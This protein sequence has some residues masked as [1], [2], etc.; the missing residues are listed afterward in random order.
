MW[1][2]SRV[3]RFPRSVHASVLG[4]PGVIRVTLTSVCG[5]GLRLGEQAQEELQLKKLLCRFVKNGFMLALDGIDPKTGPTKA[6]LIQ[7]AFSKA[8][9][10]LYPEIP[11]GKPGEGG[12][13]W[14]AGYNADPPT[15]T[16]E[17]ELTA[18]IDELNK[19]I[20]EAE[21]AATSVKKCVVVAANVSSSARLLV[22]LLRRSADCRQPD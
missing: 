16:R 5:L 1:N 6:Q 4:G 22:R 11:Q 9:P 17:E 3:R 13:D 19:F 21:Q 2:I 7:Q 14:D 12:H 15:L 8:Y 18:M 10:W 20:A